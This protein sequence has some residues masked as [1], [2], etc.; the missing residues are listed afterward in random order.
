MTGTSPVMTALVVSVGLAK[1]P[2]RE[3]GEEDDQPGD[4]FSISWD[5]NAL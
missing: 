2:S 4:S 1:S 3:E 5:F